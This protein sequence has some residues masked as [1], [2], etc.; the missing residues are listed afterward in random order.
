MPADERIVVVEDV[1]EI[2]SPRPRVVA[3]QGRSAN[4][5]GVGQVS[6][7][8]LIRQALRMRADWLV[9]GDAR[10]HPVR[11]AWGYG[12]QMLYIVPDLGLTVVMTSDATGARDRGH[13]D[14]LNGLLADGI[15]PAAEKGGAS[16]IW[17]AR[18]AA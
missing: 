16:P 7:S 17:R 10:G 5:E 1:R 12:G 14:A 4:V 9:V 11:F 3:L 6:M 13:I 2:R 18:E 15:E 8:D